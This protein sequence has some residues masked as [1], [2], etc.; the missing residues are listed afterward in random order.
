MLALLATVAVLAPIAWL[1]WDSTMPSTYSV[2]DMGRP[3]LGGGPAGP[4]AAGT[5]DGA[6]AGMHGG[7]GVDTL[8]ETSTAPAD[9]LVTVTARRQVFRLPS[10]QQVDGYTLNGTSPG[11][12]IRAVQ[13]QIVQI[14]LVNESVPGGVTLHWHGVDVPNGDDGTAGV[15]QDAVPPGGEF[16]YRFTAR[17]AGTY[18]YHS[19]QVAH[20]QVQKGLFGAL[21][22]APAAAPAGPEALALV[23]LYDGHRTVNGRSGDVPV[24]AAPGSRV[25]VRVVNTDNGPMSAWV[26][27]APFRLVAVDG[28]DVNQPSP[29]S[30]QAV[31]VTAG[32][33]ADLEVAVPADGS[34]ARVELG[35]DTAM[36]FGRPLAPS[37]KPAVTLDT[38]AYGTPAPLGFDPAAADRTFGYA[39]GRRPGF[40]DGRPGLWWTV[41]G[42]MWPD[43]PM[44]VVSEGD[45]VRVH[46][47]NTSGDVHPMHL[48]GHHAV[49]LARNGVPAT[50]SPW[51]VD[52]LDVGDGESYDIAFVADNPGIWMDH[53]HNLTHAAEGLVAHL[54]YTGISEP[55][56][57]GG[58]A[59]NDPE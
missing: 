39:V 28:T 48:H 40:V 45:V 34:G 56:R 27:G 21:V 23:H 44:F 7:R 15:T 33:R 42:H 32:G 30:G 8:R 9:V 14:R 37:R 22:I 2:M 1:W 24:A 53:C 20:E 10:G 57:V 16:T 19:H 29:V 55:F 17:D 12:E 59:A 43:V 26:T 3:D 49:V 41:N 47:T 13:G 36:V 50:G 18:W 11:P 35:G 46:I 58:D 51:W 38:L 25:R 6:H 54:M 4:P 5:H 31:T 52:T